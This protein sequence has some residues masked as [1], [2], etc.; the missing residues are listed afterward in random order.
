MPGELLPYIFISLVMGLIGLVI[1]AMSLQIVESVVNGWAWFYTLFVTE[2]V[3]KD[4]RAEVRSGLYE[5]KVAL[6]AE[7]HDPSAA[8][9]LLFLQMVAG[10]R[11]DLVWV[12]PHL[13]GKIVHKLE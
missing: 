1:R 12:S 13:A 5:G 9:V 6:I 3:R 4:R 11:H 8:A 2:D 7:G 10:M